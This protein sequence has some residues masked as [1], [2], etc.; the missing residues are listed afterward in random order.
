MSFYRSDSGRKGAIRMKRFAIAVSM[1]LLSATMVAAQG[2]DATPKSSTP[3]TAP[4]DA[5]MISPGEL[6]PTPEMWFYQQYL[7]QYQDPKA[8]LH[9]KGDLEATQRARRL[10]A[11]KWFGLSNQRP[12]VA[13]DALHSD[14][15]PSWAS[16]NWYYPFRWQAGPTPVIITPNGH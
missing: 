7:R 8:M 14:S 1:V 5:T 3:K 15:S 16:N 4:A 6:K 9:M 13:I 2:K 12:R 11:M 10:N